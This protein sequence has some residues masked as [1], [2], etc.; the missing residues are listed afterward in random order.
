MGEAR[1]SW[2]G[3]ATDVY[4]WHIQQVLGGA[5]VGSHLALPQALKHLGELGDTRVAESD[6]LCG[7]AVTLPTCGG[8]VRTQELISAVRLEP[9]L[10]HN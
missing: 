6:H 5:D 3:P 9:C 8:P 4:S 7:G 1:P 2:E 10:A